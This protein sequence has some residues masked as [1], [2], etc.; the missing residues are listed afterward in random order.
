[1]PNAEEITRAL[2]K[3]VQ[4]RLFEECLPRIEICLNKLSEEQVWW[5]PNKESNSIGN[6][7]LHL[8]GNVRQWIL[9]GIGGE[10]DNRKRDSEFSLEGGVT[11]VQ[12]LSSL[13]RTMQDVQPVIEH[14]ASENILEIRDVQVF[15]ESV[16]SILVHVTEHFSYHTGQI[17]WITKMITG[18]QVNF[19]GDTDLG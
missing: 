5:R 18:Q 1:M 4:R 17:T 13:Q 7:I 15:R 14:L 8:D 3:E 19:Y 12:L 6:L 11:K 16:L 2:K 9:T 10:A